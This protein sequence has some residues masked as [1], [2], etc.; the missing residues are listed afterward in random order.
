MELIR[1]LSA[2]QID[3]RERESVKRLSFVGIGGNVAVAVYPKNRGEMLCILSYL[4]KR[5]VPYRVFGNMSN[6]L[7]PDGFW[8]ICLI[9]TKRMRALSFENGLAVAECGAS[10]SALCRYMKGVG[11]RQPSAL[12]GIPA[13]VGG[14]V[15]QNAG[16]FGT[17]ISACFS[18][19]DVYDPGQDAVFRLSKEEMRFS[20]RASA[21]RFRGILLSAAFSADPQ[22]EGMA[23]SMEAYLKK[24]HELQP[25]GRSLGSVFLRVGETSAAYYIDRAGLKG[26]RIGGAEISPIHAGF[27][28]NKD[29]ATAEDYRALV[30][31]AKARVYEK[32]S[33]DLMP[34]IEIIEN[35]RENVWL[36]SI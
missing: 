35:R 36:H 17:E 21:L 7:P 18:Y 5:A 12:I 4:H 20:Y 30:N 23:L 27:I 10:V 24:R 19:A 15:Y 11:L 9:S 34:E 13:T 28:M 6:V 16:A 32:F 22:A 14:A 8:G 29:G 25:R 2:H 33:V 1:F 31:L 26:K 3:Y